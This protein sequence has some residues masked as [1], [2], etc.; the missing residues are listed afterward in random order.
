M[1]F[2]DSLKKFIKLKKRVWI[3]SIMA[4]ELLTFKQIS[5]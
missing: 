4:Q 5:P 1:I 3:V 2:L